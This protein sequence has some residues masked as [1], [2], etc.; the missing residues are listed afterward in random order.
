MSD[1]RATWLATTREAA[2]EPA[3][4][5]CDPHHH[6]WDLPGSRYLLEELH[7]DTGSGHNVIETVFLECGSE[8]REG[9]PTAMEPVGETEFVARIAAASEGAAGATIAAIVGYAD[10]RLGDAVEEVLAAHVAWL[11]SDACSAAGFPQARSEGEARRRAE[12]I[13]LRNPAWAKEPDG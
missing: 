3:L 10:L 12:E 11:Q 5:I 8:Y 7:E 6:L 1:D 2:I 13:V 4:A 9:G